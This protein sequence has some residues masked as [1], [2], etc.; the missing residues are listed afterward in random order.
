MNRLLSS[1]ELA[2]AL[3]LNPQTLRMW[4]L[5]G[6]GPP[7]VKFG[8]SKRARVRYDVERVQEWLAERTVER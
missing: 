3:G 5:T 2:E 1:K 6:D 7:Y 4:R 8:D